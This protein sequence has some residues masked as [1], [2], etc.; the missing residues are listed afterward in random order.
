MKK[1]G[2]ILKK[3][4]A[5]LLI[6][7]M[8]CGCSAVS[9]NLQGENMPEEPVN[10]GETVTSDSR[11][12]NSDIS[13]SLDENTKVSLKDDFHTAVNRDW[14]L[15]HRLTSEEK[16]N[17]EQYGTFE[18]NDKE[19]EERLLEIIHDTES[20]ELVSAESGAGIPEE[21]TEYNRRLM[22]KFVTLASGWDD[23]NQRGIQP[24]VPYIEKIQDIKSM[25]DMTTYLKNEDGS[26]FSL[27]NCVS[28]QVTKP[29][30]ERTQN[31]VMIY[32]YDGF[33]LRQ[34]TEYSSISMQGIFMKKMND[35][36]VTYLLKKMGYGD[37]EIQRILASGYKF[38]SRLAEI[39]NL[40]AQQSFYS[41]LKV[42]DNTY[43][44]GELEKLQGNF[45]LTEILQSYGL[46]NSDTYTV[47]EPDY[48]RELGKL[49]TEKNLEEI[50]AFYIMHTLT[51]AIM[52]LDRE[53]FDSYLDF[54]GQTPGT[55]TISTTQTMEDKKKREELFQYYVIPYMSEV[56]DQIYIAKYCEKSE[57]EDLT[58]LVQDILDTYHELLQEETWLSEEARE[59]AIEK[60]DYMKM[61]V[62]YP[63]Q[64]RDYRQLDLDQYDN[65]VDMVAAVQK[66]GMMTMQEQVN[67][68]VDR[69]AW[70]LREQATIQGNAFYAPDSNSFNI[71]AGLIA[72]GEFYSQDMTYE[73]KLAHIGT[74]IG[75]EITHAFDNTGSQFDKEGRKEMWWSTEDNFAF[76]TKT[77]RVIKF[78]NALVPYP[79][80]ETYD[81]SKVAGEAIADMGGLACALK[82]AEKKA[83]FNYD[84]FFTAYA[85]GWRACRS[86]NHEKDYAFGDEHPLAY[87][88]T[89]VTLQQFDKFYETYD[90]QPGDGM[91]YPPE[92][93]IKIW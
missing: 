26:N 42:A 5:S 16:K 53:T 2:H 87:L 74:V 25:E 50:K 38:E 65:L 9:L 58:L 49:F 78:Y 69:N 29:L 30:K 46:Q 57:K 51:S 12:I 70:D 20:D 18:D 92:K 4:T 75:H 11:W 54:I 36:Q 21:Q 3:M 56:L 43:T 72:D 17:K 31:T 14:L 82:M 6:V 15:E 47:T 48:I 23:R 10:P 84:E 37:P 68:P 39:Q 63:D 59:K 1:Q 40:T 35:G 73:E 44:Y 61:N 45:P 77:T 85:K 66:F 83:D 24:L 22:K 88:R 34:A 64:F 8:L 27:E 76:G 32:P 90:I 89:N 13:G 55:I 79:G 71:L 33:F 86:L 41:Y 62:L 28:L 52:L 91:Y 81:G 19:L 67:Q 80:A 7:S 93:R 60:L